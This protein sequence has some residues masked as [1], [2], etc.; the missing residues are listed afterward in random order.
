[1]VKHENPITAEDISID[2]PKDKEVDFRAM[3]K[4]HEEDLSR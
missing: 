3:L 4:N 1:M 2:I